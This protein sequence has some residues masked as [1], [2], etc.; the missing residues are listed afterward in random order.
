MW[1]LL[2]NFKFEKRAFASIIYLLLFLSCKAQLLYPVVGTYKNKTAQSMT[3]H[4][5]CAYLFN[6][7]GYCRIY[8]LRSL[9]LESEFSL[10]S[11]RFSTHINSAS[12]IAFDDSIYVYS[13]ECKKSYRCFVEKIKDNQ[14]LLVQIIV[15]KSKEKILPVIVWVLNPQDNTIVSITRD[16]RTLYTKG[17]S[18]HT[19][20]GYKLPDIYSGNYIEL[21]ENDELYRFPVHFSSIMQDAVIKDNLLFISSGN[22]QSQADKAFS[23][24]A[25]QIVDLNVHKLVHSIDITL[26][27]TNEPEGLDFY[28]DDLLLFCGQEGGIY[29]IEKEW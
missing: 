2:N 7:S 5:N 11:S 19:I 16:T 23:K 20:R 21:S 17:Y 18:I 27:S 22:Q 9:K 10:A 26:L 4:N 28:N 29:K 13:S 1:T 6:D 15:A 25:I 24:R 14:A 12:L 3:I 8:D